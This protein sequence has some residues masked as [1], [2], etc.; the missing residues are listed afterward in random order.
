MVKFSNSVP[1]V[2]ITTPIS[3]LCANFVKFVPQKIGEIVHFLPHTQTKKILPGSPAVATASITLK[4]C[5]GQPPTMYSECSR[6]HPNQF[7]FGIDIAECVNIAKTCHKVNP[8]SGWSLASSQV[9]KIC[10]FTQK[11]SL[12]LHLSHTHCHL[13]FNIPV[14]VYLQ[15]T[16]FTVLEMRICYTVAISE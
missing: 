12:T 3:V 9:C 2:F 5:Q 14:L 15:L 8:I 6:F 1:N 4:M 11:C 13:Q 7:T 10:Y 16:C